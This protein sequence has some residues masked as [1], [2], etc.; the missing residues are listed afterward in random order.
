MDLSQRTE[1]FGQDDQSW[2]GSSHGTDMARSVTLD[3]SMFTA[4]THFPS[5]YFKS[6]IP[7]AR[8]TGTGQGGEVGKYGPYDDT[9]TDGRQ[10]LAGFLLTAVRAPDVNADPQGAL[11][12]H[13]VVV[14]SKLPI[15][16]DAA[17]KADVA[18][19]IF[20]A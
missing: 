12:I 2:L 19:R 7:I 13:G 6:G 9:A 10:T 11:Y 20:F 18:G 14:E 1:T 3:K 15:A 16:V 4:G 5:G 17:G 8:I